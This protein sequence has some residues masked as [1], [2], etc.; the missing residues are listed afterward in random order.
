M[1]DTIGDFRRNCVVSG[2]ANLIGV[3]PRGSLV[4]FVMEWPLIEDLKGD[5]SIF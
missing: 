1:P 4:S 3:I 2:F 5:V